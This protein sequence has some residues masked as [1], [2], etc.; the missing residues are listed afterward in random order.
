[1]EGLDSQRRVVEVK[2]YDA[3]VLLSVGGRRVPPPPPTISAG[4][5]AIDREECQRNSRS[6]LYSSC[7]ELFDAHSRCALATRPEECRGLAIQTYL[8]QT[9]LA[10]TPRGE[11]AAGR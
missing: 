11:S 8:E 3:G 10:E 1:M 7:R 9:H 5:T 6:V 4:T 2:V